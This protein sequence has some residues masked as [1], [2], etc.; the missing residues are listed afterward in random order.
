M[1]LGGLNSDVVSQQAI[2]LQILTQLGSIST[3]LDA[4]ENKKPKKSNDVSKLKSKSTKKT[5]VPHTLVTLPP[6]TSICSVA[7]RFAYFEKRCIY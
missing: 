3:H 2:N 4:I 5:V 6:H 7:S 1:T